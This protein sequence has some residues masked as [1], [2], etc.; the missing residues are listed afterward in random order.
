M[1]QFRNHSG[2]LKPATAARPPKQ[3]G[4]DIIKANGGLGSFG[5]AADLLKIKFDDGQDEMSDGGSP[6]AGLGP[7]G[8]KKQPGPDGGVTRSAFSGPLEIPPDPELLER[9]VGATGDVKLSHAL[10][11][12]EHLDAP[13]KTKA[14]AGWNNFYTAKDLLKLSFNEDGNNPPPYKDEPKYGA[15]SALRPA[16]GSE[17]NKGKI[18]SKAWNSAM[19]GKVPTG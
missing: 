4:P 9:D 10:R 13:N 2:P 14:N 7:N 12:Q 11:K 3:N 18:V 5:T 6:R 17:R 15:N 1:D 8:R 16:I 19:R